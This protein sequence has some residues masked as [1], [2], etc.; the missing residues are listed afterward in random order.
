MYKAI[1]FDLGRVAVDFDFQR[2]FQAL[3]GFCP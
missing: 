1:V 3:E 2:G